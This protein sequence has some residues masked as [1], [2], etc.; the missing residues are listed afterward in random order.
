MHRADRVIV[1]YVYDREVD[2]GY[3]AR[4]VR[5]ATLKE[6]LELMKHAFTTASNAPHGVSP[7][8]WLRHAVEWAQ[9]Y[10]AEH[11]RETVPA[12][13]LAAMRCPSACG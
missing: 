2:N 7:A 13:V 9:A 6:R 3:F 8:Q 4:S 5:L 12:A 11:C 1:R 10:H